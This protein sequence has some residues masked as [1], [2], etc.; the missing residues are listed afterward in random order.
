MTFCLLPF[1]GFLAFYFVSPSSC[2]Q[3]YLI[4]LD[5]MSFCQAEAEKKRKEAE[6]AAADPAVQNVLQN[7]ELR[8]IL[9]DP[10]MRAV[11]QECNDP[12]VRPMST[13]PTLMPQHH[14]YDCQPINNHNANANANADVNADVNAMSIVLFNY[15]QAV[16]RYMRDPVYGPKL[17][18]MVKHGLLQFQ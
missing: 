14:C 3:F 11:L 13:R 4:Q 17:R 5:A 9:M 12:R 16:Q 10:K 2:C 1:C 6:A 15:L 7:E 8:A 18:L